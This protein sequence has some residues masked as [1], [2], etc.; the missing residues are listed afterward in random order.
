MPTPNETQSP[1]PGAS[2]PRKP[3]AAA[4]LAKYSELAFVLPA[5]AIGGWLLGALLDKQFGTHWIY[6]LG[7]VLGFIGG[8]VRII[9]VAMGKAE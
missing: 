2:E 1:Q 6:L 8:F 7:L 3:S 4:Q 5:G 9:R